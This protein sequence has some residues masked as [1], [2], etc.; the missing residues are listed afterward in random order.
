[1]KKENIFITISFIFIISLILF[2]G[3]RLVYFYKLTHTSEKLGETYFN[4]IIKNKSYDKSIISD[5]KN[6]YYSGNVLN[7]YLYYSNRYFRIVGLEN[8]NIILV[9]DSISTILP[10]N[11]INSWLNESIYYNSL[12][13]PSEL[14]TTTKTCTDEE[15]NNYTESSVGIIS[16]KQYKRANNNGNYLN[17]NS[18]YWLSDGTFINDK[19]NILDNDEGLY[20][21]R[22]TIT[23][24]SDVLYYGGTGTYYDPYFIDLEDA[25]EFTNTKAETIKVGSYITYSDKTWRVIEISDNI[26]LALNDTIGNFAFSNLSNEF[27][28]DD[29]S[30]IA[31][32]LNN[33]F[34]NS[35]N[36]DLLVKGT[37]HTGSFT[38]S[39]LDKY[40]NTQ[41]EYVGLME[42]GDLFM[43]D[44]DN[45]FTLTNTGLRNTIYKVMSGKF[46]A[47]SYKSENKIRPVI[48][49]P[50]DINITSGYG[51]IDSPFE[52]GEL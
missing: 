6:L 16:L 13:K 1:M 28:L 23:L 52:V 44:V 36:K 29:K 25:Y 27:N 45:Y 41:E 18:F 33:T 21:V 9:D 38:N 10:F 32:Y 17:N 3:T 2:Y 24:K 39:Y 46:Y 7:N 15:C 12:Y 20:G 30:S 50:K 8:D 19:A 37:L 22:I 34:L 11:D 48:F 49:L 40:K 47:D 14:L 51:T 5:G 42:I 31:Y 4:T 43:Y 35:L 26:K